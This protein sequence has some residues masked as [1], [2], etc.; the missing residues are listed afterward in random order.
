MKASEDSAIKIMMEQMASQAALKTLATSA[1]VLPPG[2]VRFQTFASKPLPPSLP[3]QGYI[4]AGPINDNLDMAVVIALGITWD[5]FYN[6]H[7]T[8]VPPPPTNLMRLPSTI[9]GKEEPN[10]AQIATVFQLAY[11]GARK[12]IWDALKFIPQDYQDAPVYFT[13]MWL[14][15]PMAQICALDLRSG[16]T[17]PDQQAGPSTP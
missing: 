13:G 10:D 4:A 1:P 11:S 9:A 8:G 5:N 16:N 2:W 15:A 14:G 6:L 3:V 17:G 7:L 12:T